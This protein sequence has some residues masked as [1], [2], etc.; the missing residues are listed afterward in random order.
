MFLWYQRTVKNLDMA[1]LMTNYSNQNVIWLEQGSVE[2]YFS[3]QIS[4][5]V[6]YDAPMVTSFGR[7]SFG[8]YCISLEP[9]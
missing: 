3:R 6:F 5:T 7:M 2:D 8:C 1:T 4:P 9:V